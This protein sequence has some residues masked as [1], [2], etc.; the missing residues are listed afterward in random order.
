MS[1][2]GHMA[3]K[4]FPEFFLKIRTLFIKH[5]IAKGNK[6]LKKKGKQETSKTLLTKKTKIFLCST[7]SDHVF[8]LP[9]TSSSTARETYSSLLCLRFPPS[10][11]SSR[12]RKYYVWER[13]QQ[14]WRRPLSCTQVAS[15]SCWS[16]AQ[17]KV[18]MFELSWWKEMS[19]VVVLGWG[20]R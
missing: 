19:M 3:G 1:N 15:W 8:L 14:V 12:S 2:V 18:R 5:L 6:V 11:S 4:L 13:L 9:G 7:N 10:L 17:S 20:S 16:L